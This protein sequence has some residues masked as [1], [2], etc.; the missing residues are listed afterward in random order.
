MYLIKV[1]SNAIESGFR[2]IKVRRLGSGDIQTPRQAAPFGIDSAPRAGMVAVYSE[3]GKRGKPVIVGYL[4]KSLL[5]QDGET[6][7]YSVKA[8]GDLS[9]FIWLNDDGT[10]QIGGSE[11]NMVRF[12]ELETGFNQL[13]TDLNNLVSAYNAHVHTGVTTGPGSSGPTASQGTASTA[14]IEDAKI[15][16]IKTL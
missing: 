8:N 1:I 5:A 4:N 9:T 14:S 15:D 12:Q 7:F 6:R 10:M 2:K 11:K 13:K 16:E 3:T